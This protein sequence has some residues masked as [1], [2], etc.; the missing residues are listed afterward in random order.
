M[1]KDLIVLGETKQFSKIVC[2]VVLLLLLSLF[3]CFC[4]SYSF[5][6]ESGLGKKEK[7]WMLARANTQISVHFCCYS[8]ALV[9]HVWCQR[10]LFLGSPWSFTTSQFC[11]SKLTL[12][13][14]GHLRLIWVP[15]ASGPR[16]CTCE[17]M[18]SSYGDIVNVGSAPCGWCEFEQV[19][20]WKC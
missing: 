15:H 19:N 11:P 8:F 6:T 17:N 7:V 14:N 3:F 13:L 18:Q 16:N 1:H 2:E 5:P 9:L 12:L 10:Q 4:Q 20:L